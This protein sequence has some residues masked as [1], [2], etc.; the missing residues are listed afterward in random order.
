MRIP[1]RQLTRGV[2]TAAVTLAAAGLM[3]FTPASLEQQPPAGAAQPPAGGRQG[4]GRQG[5]PPGG[6]QR[7]PSPPF[8]DTAQVVETIGAPVRVVPMLKGLAS[9]WSLAFLPN[10]DMLITE[11]PGKLRI[12]RGGT[13]DPQPIA[14]TPEVFAVGQGGLLEVAIHP[15][16]A[17]NQFVYLTYSKG[18]G[19]QGTTA[20]A[21]GRFDG[22]ALVDVKDL[23]VTDNWNTGGVHFGSKLAF[24]R[25]GMLYM[26][27]GERNDRTRAQNTNIHGGKIL[28]LKDDGSVPTDNPFV[29]KPGYKPEIYTYGHRNLQGLAVH[30]DTGALWE[31]EHG[32]QGG[33]ELNLIQAGKNYG[34]PVVTLGR[35]SSGEVISPQPAREDIEQPFIFWAP[36]PGLS[37]MVIYTGDKFP[38]WKGQFFLGALAGTGVW[39]V[40]MNDKGLAGRELLLGSLKQRIRDVRQ[41]PDGFLYLVVDANPG[42]ILRVEPAPSPA[43]SGQ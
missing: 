5:P 34:W 29:G 16:F 10:G 27:V 18:K 39:R 9:P 20:L 23:L 36:S 14:G 26:T 19:D 11:K 37:G 2:T 21:R 22:K 3:A 8:P 4:G 15:Q 35:E 40:G 25:D 24:G 28:R 33:D 12:V 7:P 38:Q 43:G 32:P 31:T 1:A 41:G 42:G 30:P 13:L 6:F 17:Q